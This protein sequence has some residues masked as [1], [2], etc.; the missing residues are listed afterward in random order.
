VIIQQ[1]I[2]TAAS[3]P[4]RVSI[5]SIHPLPTHRQPICT[6]T[7]FAFQP[8]PTPTPSQRRQSGKQDSPSSL[9]TRPPRHHPAVCSAQSRDC[10]NNRFSDPT[11]TRSTVF[12]QYTIN[13]PPTPSLSSPRPNRSASP[14]SV[15]NTIH[16]PI[17]SPC[18]LHPL[19]P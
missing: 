11:G 17:W 18:L 13:P 5:A 16:S 2:R 14:G 6:F 1:N 10:R 12:A 15:V 9:V 7:F 4:S 3:N 8:S 19:E